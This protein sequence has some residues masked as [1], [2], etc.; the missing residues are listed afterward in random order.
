MYFFV[1]TY[2]KIETNTFFSCNNIDEV[3]YIV[4]LY[5]NYIKYIVS[6]CGINSCNFELRMRGYWYTLF[7]YFLKSY[8]QPST[9]LAFT[10]S[11]NKL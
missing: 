6:L 5:F 2:F 7:S 10:F 4:I 1:N 8:S 11:K 3:H 9:Y